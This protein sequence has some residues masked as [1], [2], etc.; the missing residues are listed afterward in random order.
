MGV[1]VRCTD[2]ALLAAQ[3]RRD[4]A[5]HAYEL[6]DLDDA[7]WPAATF[8]TAPPAVALVYRGGRVPT[9]LALCA[10]D[11][12]AA[13]ARLLAGLMAEGHVPDE[14]YA[15]LSPGL[16]QEL[17]RAYTLEAHGEHYKLAL[18]AERL[19]GLRQGA[20]DGPDDPGLAPLAERDRA[21]LLAFYGA[22]YPG[23]WFEP[24]MLATRRYWG[25]RRDAQLLAVAGVHVVS[26][27]YGVAA[28]GNVAT[29]RAWRGRG[30]GR[31]VTARLCRQL[32]AEVDTITLNVK[33]DNAPAQALYRGLGF[34]AV[35]RYGEYRCRR[36]PPG[37]AAGPARAAPRRRGP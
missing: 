5:L 17:A 7:F 24:H 22:H 30:L 1:V 35:A 11:Q 3:L 23:H 20:C 14:L 29:H 19:A 6:G 9:L 26:A 34:A 37:I 8:F 2:R 16:E 27:T 21:E 31:A 28:L 32:A 12:H 36:A 15:H 4:P 25:L 33:A 10:P 18:G 13:T